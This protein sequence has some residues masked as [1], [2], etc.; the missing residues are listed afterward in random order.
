MAWGVT[1]AQYGVVTGVLGFKFFEWWYTPEVQELAQHSS[2]EA[3]SPPPPVEWL[4]GGSVLGDTHSI[5]P[6]DTASVACPLCHA[7]CTNMAA[8]P[9]GYIY[10]F[11]CLYKYIEKY[12]RTPKGGLPCNVLDIRKC[13][14]S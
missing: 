3:A 12:G 10:C 11:P 9:S 1:L 7:Q 14:V 6:P 4:G 8:S 2:E 13:W 5:V